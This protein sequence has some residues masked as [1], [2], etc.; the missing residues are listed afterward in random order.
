MEVQLYFAS[1]YCFIKLSDRYNRR[2]EAP[3]EL[4]DARKRTA[5]H[6]AAESGQSDNV[7]WLISQGAAFWFLN[8]VREYFILLMTRE[9]EERCAYNCK[10]SFVATADL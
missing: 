6:Y 9:D 8:M 7:Q 5:M 1:C 10:V 2:A 3:L 4:T